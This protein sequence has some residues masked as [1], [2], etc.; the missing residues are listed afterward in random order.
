VTGVIRLIKTPT[1]VFI[2][3]AAV[4]LLAFMFDCVDSELV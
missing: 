4:I 2:A 3:V 1:G